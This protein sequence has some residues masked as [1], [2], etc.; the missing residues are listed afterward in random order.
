MTI[1]S[2]TK[3]IICGAIEE[4]I[5]SLLPKDI[6]IEV[7]DSDHHRTPKMLGSILQDAIDDSDDEI[8][9]IILGY[10]LCS[11]ALVGLKA[12]QSKL[13]IPRVDDC[14]ALLLGSTEAYKQ[15]TSKEPGTYYLTK[16]LMD[17][18]ITPFEEHEQLIS[19][20]GKEQAEFMTNLLL[21]NFKRLVFI[22]N[23]NNNS[24]HY[25][26]LSRSSAKQF[27]LR[28]EEITGT[29]QYFKKLLFGPWDDD[30]VIIMPYHKIT[31]LDFKNN[32]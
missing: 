10:G 12:N 21:N 31:Y 5:Q 7:I 15:Q 14:I 6:N 9:T 4:E 8:D 19:K 26:N 25:C 3:I 2:T 17:A 22:N 28:F 16:G 24:E 29:N 1:L 11:L 32:K 27:G 23:Q 30:F 18:G 13:I 20:Y